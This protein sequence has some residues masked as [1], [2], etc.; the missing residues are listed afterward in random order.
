MSE[1]GIVDFIHLYA[2]LAQQIGQRYGVP[3]IDQPILVAGSQ[4]HGWRC[5]RNVLNRL[6]IQRINYPA[7]CASAD[8]SIE[9][10]E[11]LGARQ[12]DY[13]PNAIAWPRRDTIGWVKGQHYRIIGPGRM[14]HQGGPGWVPP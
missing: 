8:F 9:R 5:A 12:P 11:V 7:K 3:R 10:V 14:P 4:Q 1:L 13:T 2:S 6:S